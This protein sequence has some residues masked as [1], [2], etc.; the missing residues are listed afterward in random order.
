MAIRRAVATD[1]WTVGPIFIAKVDPFSLDIYTSAGSRSVSLLT[2][3]FDN[4][5]EFNR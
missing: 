5:G 4:P 1:P 2:T 3:N